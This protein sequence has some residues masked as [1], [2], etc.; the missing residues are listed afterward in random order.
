MWINVATSW[1]PTR[2]GSVTVGIHS[3]RRSIN[4]RDRG[5]NSKM[6]A[7]LAV[8]DQSVLFVA[9]PNLTQSDAGKNIE[10]GWG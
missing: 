8:A 10:A 7:K 6:H 3:S 1:T 9:S 5:S 2:S 4:A